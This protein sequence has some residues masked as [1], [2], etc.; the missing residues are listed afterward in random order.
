M[1]LAKE[2]ELSMAVMNLLALEEHLAFTIA[3]TKNNDY[4]ELYNAIR[5]LRSKHMKRLVKND[6]GEM[7]CSAKHLL[8][9]VMHLIETGIKYGAEGKKKQ[10]MELFQDAIEAYQ[11]VWLMQ[12]IGGNK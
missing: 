3:K 12:N 8:I 11:A 10:A 2:Q 6:E 4:L 1:D 5:K 7:W 9:S